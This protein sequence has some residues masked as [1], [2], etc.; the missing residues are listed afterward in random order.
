MQFS[1]PR[2]ARL[3]IAASLAVTGAVLMLAIL[4][5]LEGTATEMAIMVPPA[6]IGAFLS[7][8]LLAG[9]FG[10]NDK[11]GWLWALLGAL[12]A[13]TL[14]SF[15]GGLIWHFLEGLPDGPLQTGFFAFLVVMVIAPASQPLLIGPW[16]ALMIGVHIAA[17]FIRRRHTLMDSTP[18][19][20]T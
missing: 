10:Q 13:T 5:V 14:G 19:P 15:I 18:L 4:V 9:L 11:A 12:L 3:G 8:G 16:L 7:G 6:A 2:L 17:F 20:P 1:M